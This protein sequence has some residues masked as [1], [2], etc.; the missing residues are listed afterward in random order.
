M[1]SILKFVMNQKETHY[2]DNV[3]NLKELSNNV[4][5]SHG[6]NDCSIVFNTSHDFHMWRG[7]HVSVCLFN[8]AEIKL[9]NFFICK[10][11]TV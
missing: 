5:R 9:L 6:N 7:K 4:I 1:F 8:D 3:A 10:Q 2:A 11:N